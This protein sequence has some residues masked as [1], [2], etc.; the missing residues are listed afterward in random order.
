M[1]DD[2]SNEPQLGLQ[3]LSCDNNT[4][5]PL[6]GNPDVSLPPNK[7]EDNIDNEEVSLEASI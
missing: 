1:V 3:V 6:A 7:S 4:S 5:K 2:I